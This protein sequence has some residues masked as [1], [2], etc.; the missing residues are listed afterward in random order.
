[1]NFPSSPTLGDEYSFNNKTW[2]WNGEAWDRKTIPS[3]AGAFLETDAVIS[4][5]Y[6]ISVGKNAITGGPVTIDDNVTVTI[7]TGSTWIIV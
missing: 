5:D 2:V 4:A 3:S 7:P 1:M 6:T